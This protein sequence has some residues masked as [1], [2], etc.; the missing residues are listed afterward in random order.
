[1]KKYR[2][3]TNLLYSGSLIVLTI[4]IWQVA[5][6][7]GLVPVFMLP[8]PL[9]VVHALVGDLSTLFK[10]AWVTF[11]EAAL[12]LGIGIVLGFICAVLM[13]RF[14]IVHRSVYPLIVISQTIPTIAIAPLLVLWMGYG[15][16]PKVALIVIVTFFPVAVALFDGFRS[17]DRDMIQL[18]Q[19]MGASRTQI[20]HWVKWPASLTSFFASLRI[21]VSY[22]VV[23]AVVAEWIGGD[24]GLGVYMTLARKSYSY[25]KMFAVIFFI[26]FL[27]L[28]LIAVVRI[29]QRQTMPWEE[30]H[31]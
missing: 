4:I 6:M 1:M 31:D 8:P 19:A 13:D 28:A 21:A 5:T 23:S 17:V 12:G 26:S 16:A 15:I 10:N 9:D 20:F 30:K 3:T 25:D 22:A 29:L 11:I 7:T 14:E 27:S 24:R 2:R 18:L